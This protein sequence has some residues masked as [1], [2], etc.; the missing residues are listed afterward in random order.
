MNFNPPL[1]LKNLRGINLAIWAP[2][3]K[4]FYWFIY[5]GNNERYIRNNGTYIYQWNF[6]MLFLCARSWFETRKR[7]VDIYSR[8]N[9]NKTTHIRHGTTYTKSYLTPK[10][11][12]MTIFSQSRITAVFHHRAIRERNAIIKSNVHGVTNNNKINVN[13]GPA[14][15]A[16]C[17]WSTAIF[18]LILRQSNKI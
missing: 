6:Q 9:E 12:R 5:L 1:F 2:T 4:L 3:E 14:G 13:A 8:I 11:F 10:F 15:H 7:K 16:S 18:V 17:V